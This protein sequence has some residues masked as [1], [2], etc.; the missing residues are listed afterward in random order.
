SAGLPADGST[1]LLIE[2]RPAMGLINGTVGGDYA[3]P[4][5]DFVASITAR[6]GSVTR[7]AAADCQRMVWRTDRWMIGPGQEPPAAPSVWPGTSASYDVGYRWLGV[8]P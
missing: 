5:V 6:T 4:C 1:D 3:V 2:L 8:S 7:V